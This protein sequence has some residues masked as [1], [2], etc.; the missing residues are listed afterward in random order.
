MSREKRD[1][2]IGIIDYGAGNT[3][4]V[5]RAFHRLGVKSIVT[6]NQMELDRCE[7]LVIPGVGA[8]GQAMQ[9]LHEKGLDVAIQR[10]YVAEK[11]MLGICLGMQ[12]ALEGSDEQ[13]SYEG[14]GL[15]KG[16]VRPIP[17][18]ESN[19]IPHMGWNTNRWIENRDSKESEG[20]TYFVHSYYVDCEPS[21]IRATTEY[22]ISI[23]SIIQEGSF[24]GMQ[25]HPEKSG[26]FGM[27]LLE[28]WIN[29]GQL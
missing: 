13:G 14:L 4:N 8:F 11:P 23:P 17:A 12:L 24:T 22:G 6:D 9:R 2:M 15:I 18:S 20:Y 7:R 26:A 10:W 28:Q 21:A 16:W 5:Q 3:Y 1:K 25:F 27:Q 29:R 19:P